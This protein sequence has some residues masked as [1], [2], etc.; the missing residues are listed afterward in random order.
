MPSSP[1]L[2]QER[3]GSRRGIELRGRSLPY[4]GVTWGREQQLSQTWYPGNPVAETQVIGPRF[5]DITMTGTWKDINLFLDDNAPKLI[6]F[7]RISNAALPTSTDVGG[8][9]FISGQSIENQRARRARVLRDAFDRIVASGILLRI[10]WGSL[11]RFGFLKAA[12]FPHEREEDIR[13]ELT[14]SIIGNTDAQPKPQPRE[15]DMISAFRRAIELLER[16]IRRMQGA[17]ARITFFGRGPN[18]LRLT[19]GIVRMGALITEM[20]KTLGLFA[21]LI[22]VPA[23]ILGT[24]IQTLR[25]I[26]L[27]AQLITLE[28][29]SRGAAIAAA[30]GGNPADVA[31]ANA[32]QQEIRLAAIQAAAEA[33]SSRADIERLLSS[34]LKGIH[35]A[36]A[37]ETLRDVSRLF[38]DTESNWRIIASFNGFEGSLLAVGT[39]IRVPQV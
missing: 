12:Q 18:L 37:G 11:V 36:R 3:F 10:E 28:F 4:R 31:S 24:I 6:N 5:P 20:L 39:V 13:W 22:F 35:V 25:S 38:Y 34:S 15:V 32:A 21:N 30:F 19:Q 16:L 33:A 14:F 29:R 17:F 27:E 8:T 26:Q 1:L 7:P 2:I 23:N 9:T